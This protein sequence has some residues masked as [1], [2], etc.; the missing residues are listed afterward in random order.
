MRGLL[1][2]AAA[3]AL[4]GCDAEL[5]PEQPID[6]M[7]EVWEKAE[8]GTSADLT[9]VSAIDAKHAFVVGDKGTLLTTVDGER[10]ASAQPEIFGGAR[11]VD[12]DFLNTLVG[13]VISEGKL[14][15]T[16]DGARSWTLAKDF[17][18]AFNDKLRMLRWITPG[19]GFVLG[20]KSL[21]QT[22]DGG[23]SWTRVTIENAT[24]VARARSLVYVAGDRVY[25]TNLTGTFTGVPAVNSLCTSDGCA[26]ALSFVTD[27]AGYL[28]GGSSGYKGGWAG[29]AES[30]VFK[31]TANAGAS[32]SDLAAKEHFSGQDLRKVL[33]TFDGSIALGFGT[34]ERGWLL[35]QGALLATRDGGQ[36]WVAQKRF[37]YPQLRGWMVQE[38]H[39]GGNYYQDLAIVDAAQGWL[40]GREGRLYRFKGEMFPPMK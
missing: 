29:Y 30:F 27:D 1:V 39:A 28:I 2:A 26:A 10:W 11:L 8:I 14:F 12:V 20:D 16:E 32:W 36:R 31:K 15:R 7:Q 37:D 6:Y 9:G 35:Y 4:A 19:V 13:Y 38:P 25:K 21:Y 40:V 3:I 5:F 24:T 23:E 18:S 17:G 22:L 33:P 34:P